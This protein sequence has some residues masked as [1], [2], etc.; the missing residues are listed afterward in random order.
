MPDLAAIFA[1]LADPTRLAMLERLAQGEA[2]VTELAAPFPI[3][4]PAISRHVRVL[5][6]AG[7]ILRRSEGTRRPCRL[8]PQ[9]LAPVQDWLSRL[10]RDAGA[11]PPRLDGVLAA[12]RS[13]EQTRR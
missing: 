7:L 1:A 10:P 12:M 6:E 11:R 5:E 3:S 8:A 13:F 9:A 2:S 4:Q